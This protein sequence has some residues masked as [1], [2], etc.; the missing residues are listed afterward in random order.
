MSIVVKICGLRTADAVD[1]AVSHG[2]RYAGFVFYP[3]SPRYVVPTQASSLMMRLHSDV[4]PVGLFVNPDDDELAHILRTTPLRVLQLHGDETPQRVADI[5]N[6][7]ALPVI[8]AVGIA[9]SSD[10]EAA[11]HYESITDILLLDAKAGALP[12]G[13]AVVFDWPLLRGVRFAKPWMLAGG[14]T[15]DNIAEA[16]AVT[17][18]RIL[19]V[20]SGVEDAPGDKNPQKIKDFLIKSHAMATSS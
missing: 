9:K 20:S 4:T 1:A 16:A 19:D 5:K 13:N 7:F 11:Q 12:G 8:K 18:A 2:A 14:L 15:V 6:K 3:R 10:I 17:G